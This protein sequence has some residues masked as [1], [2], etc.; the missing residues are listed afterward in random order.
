MAKKWDNDELFRACVVEGK[1][2]STF[3]TAM[4]SNDDPHVDV[5]AYYLNDDD[6]WAPTSKG[7]RI[8]AEMV[9]E[10]LKQLQLALDAVDKKVTVK[11]KKKKK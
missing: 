9:P 10:L 4:I 2:R 8:H 1:S 7:V 6:E 5:R 11:A 3:V